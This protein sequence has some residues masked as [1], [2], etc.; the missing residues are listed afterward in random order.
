MASPTLRCP[1]AGPP[2]RAQTRPHLAPA[3]PAA[4]SVPTLAAPEFD[5]QALLERQRLKRLRSRLRMA[6]QSS[7][8]AASG[9]ATADHAAA[10]RRFSRML[11]SLLD[12]L[13]QGVPSGDALAIE[14]ARRWFRA[15]RH[16][17]QRYGAGPRLNIVQCEQ[18]RRQLRLLDPASLR[19]VQLH[20]QVAA[21]MAPCSFA[22]APS[23]VPA[24]EWATPRKHRRPGALVV[25]LFY[26]ACAAKPGPTFVQIA[27]QTLTLQLNTGIDGPAAGALDRWAQ[28]GLP[29]RT[30]Y[31][32]AAAAMARLGD[33]QLNEL[34][35]RACRSATTEEIMTTVRTQW[36]DGPATEPGDGSADAAPRGAALLAAAAAVEFLARLRPGLGLPPEKYAAFRQRMAATS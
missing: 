34:V 25:Q 31:R 1:A 35:A 29:E 20:L 4:A 23:F 10:G 27:A 18:V 5:S 26:L 11:A 17:A 33:E 3:R 28:A 14:Q 15:L 30:P 8:I 12:T 7:H 19:S 24:I 32:I 22:T 16:E 2:M 13:S 6:V 9:R 21:D 36:I